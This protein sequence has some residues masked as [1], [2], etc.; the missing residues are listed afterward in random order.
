MKAVQQ[1]EKACNAVVEAF[2][3]KQDLDFDGFVGG[4]VGGVASFSCQYFF[5]IDDMVHDLKTDQPVGLILQWQEDG[6][7]AHFNGDET[8]INYKSYCMGLRWDMVNK[9]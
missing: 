2:A 6:V 4:E 8:K 3:K 5:N 9:P 7:D 1:Y